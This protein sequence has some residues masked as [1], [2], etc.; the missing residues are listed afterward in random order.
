MMLSLVKKLT[1]LMTVSMILLSSIGVSMAQIIELD[2]FMVQQDRQSLQ[3]LVD[4]TEVQQQLQAYGLNPEQVKERIGQ[5]TA[6]EL[7]TL[8]QHIEE[9][10]A[11]EYAGQVI[12]LAFALF[13][14][15][16]ITDIIGATNVFPFVQSL[17]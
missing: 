10:P 14:I 11:G 2:D 5:M 6:E 4:Q 8:N 17:N 12:G 15:F 3:A 16:L 13:V 9:L 7:E 1:A